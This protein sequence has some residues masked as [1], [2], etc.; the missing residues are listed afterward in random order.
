MSP[1]SLFQECK[2]HATTFFLVFWLIQQ[3]F[4]KFRCCI[5]YQNI[6]ILDN[7]KNDFKNSVFQMQIFMTCK[8]TQVASKNNNQTNLTKKCNYQMNKIFK[9]EDCPLCKGGYS[10]L[11]TGFSIKL[12]LMFSFSLSKSEDIISIIWF[13]IVALDENK[14][15]CKPSSISS[16]W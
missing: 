11:I 3:T 16:L 10:I 9:A 5:K 12:D 7:S 6:K 15:I 1:V 13:C 8:N 2:V 4:S 14:T